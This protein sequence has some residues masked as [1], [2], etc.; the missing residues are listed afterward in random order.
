MN[1]CETEMNILEI[2]WKEGPLPASEL[3]KILEDSIG[4]KRST[5]YT[6]LKKCIEK[7]FIER[8]DPGFICIPIIE[9]SS[10]QKAKIADIISVFFNNS[11]PNFL[12]TFLSYE[13]L[14]EEEVKELKDYVNRLK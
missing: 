13:T 2:L 6:V 12:N 4:W 11:K 1:I 5:T 8:K 9:K 3:Y 7:K 14:T 10:V